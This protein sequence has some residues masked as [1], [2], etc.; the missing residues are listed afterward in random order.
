VGELLGSARA[1]PRYV[2]LKNFVHGL[3]PFIRAQ[4][5][6]SFIRFVHSL[7]SIYMVS[8]ALLFIDTRRTGPTL[9]PH[10]E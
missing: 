5:A 10:L 8:F 9:Y 4:I 2:S 1:L 6:S 3:G 7:L